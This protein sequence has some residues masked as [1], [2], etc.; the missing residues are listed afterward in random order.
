MN[1]SHADY[2]EQLRSEM[3]KAL[4]ALAGLGN[5]SIVELSF[6][7]EQIEREWRNALDKCF[8]TIHDFAEAHGIEVEA[9]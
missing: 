1:M 3:E 7:D 6:A 9:D 5:A 2:I 8:D 4:T